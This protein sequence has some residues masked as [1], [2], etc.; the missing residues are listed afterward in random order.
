MGVLGL[1]SELVS[2]D[3]KYSGLVSYLLGRVVVV[4]QIDH[5]I[6]LAK[7]YRYS[8]R[9]VTLDGEL[10]S[11][12]GSMT[13]GSASKN[14]GLL[15]RKEEIHSLNNQAEKLRE[16]LAALEPKLRQSQEALSQ[17]QAQLTAAQAELTTCQQDHIT[18]SAEEKRL[19]LSV[20]E[21]IHN[22]DEMQK[23]YREVTQKLEQLKNMSQSADS[24]ID[25]V[26]EELSA[27]KEK[28]DKTKEIT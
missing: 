20:E 18:Y 3:E 19:S 7:K 26:S 4:D 23:E 16:K 25:Q 6:A 21:A 14:T 17:T 11:P 5:A 27:L 22:R 2:A 15:S 8:L 13:G 10:L 12:G 28:L 9:I 1:A 24:L